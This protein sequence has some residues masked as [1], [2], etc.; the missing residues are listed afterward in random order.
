LEAFGAFI[1]AFYTPFWAA[2]G[3]IR[4]IRFQNRQNIEKNVPEKEKKYKMLYLT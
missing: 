1:D 4:Q 2:Y 3:M